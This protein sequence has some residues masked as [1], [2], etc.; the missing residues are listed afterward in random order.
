MI[1]TP[2]DFLA[3]CQVWADFAQGILSVFNAVIAPFGVMFP[4]A[5]SFCLDSFNALTSLYN[6][7]PFRFGF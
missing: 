3:I 7:I 6:Q 4:T 2:A 1:R 5:R